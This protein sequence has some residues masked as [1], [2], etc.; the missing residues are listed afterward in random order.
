MIKPYVEDADSVAL[1]A[2]RVVGLLAGPMEVFS[3][4]RL[5][6]MTVCSLGGRD[7]PTIRAFLLPRPSAGAAAAARFGVRSSKRNDRHDLSYSCSTVRNAGMGEACGLRLCTNDIASESDIPLRLVSTKKEY[8]GNVT[9]KS[10]FGISIYTGVFTHTHPG[11]HKHIEHTHT[12]TNSFRS[13]TSS[14]RTKPP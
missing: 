3:G 12:H 6:P 9:I 4:P 5:G 1:D 11:Q 7:G 13:L 2:S 8:V 14:D 10:W